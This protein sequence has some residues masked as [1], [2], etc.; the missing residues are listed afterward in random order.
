MSQ[1]KNRKPLMVAAAAFA[2]GGVFF[3]IW[4]RGAHPAPWYD[5]VM[6]IFNF[7]IL[8]AAL[9]YFARKPVVEGIRSSIETV[10]TM[11]AEAEEARK[12]AESHMKEAE[13]RLAGID[14]EISDLITNAR[15]EGR[16]EKERILAEAE[17]AVE[18]LKRDAVVTF[19][20]ELKKAQDVLKTE[21]A[22][23][24]VSLAEEIINKEI[25]SE[26]QGRFV[27][28]YIEKLE[29]DR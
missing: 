16:V 6:R 5:L 25:S 7:L 19:D 27:N 13:E 2:V 26:D 21:V 10:R 29:V 15:E 22:E 12:L 14:K 1:P 18:K 20:L 9:I 8:A 24:A 11:L 28:D 4:G 3:V 23:M 17:D